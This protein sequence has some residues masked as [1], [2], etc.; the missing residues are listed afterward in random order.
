MTMRGSHNKRARLWLM[1]MFVVSA[2]LYACNEST[3]YDSYHHV[4]KVG[5]ERTDTLVYDVKPVAKEGEYAEGVGMRLN[6]EYPFIQL[7][8]VVEQMILPSRM[9][10]TDTLMCDITTA[11]GTSYGH[12]VNLYQYYLPIGSVALAEGDSLHIAVRHNMRRELLKGVLE[13]G[14]K[15]SKLE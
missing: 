2:T 5:W 3:I 9:V 15:L 8:L 7:C 14:V 1:V 6:S 11:D 12:G 10:R 4:D 13:V